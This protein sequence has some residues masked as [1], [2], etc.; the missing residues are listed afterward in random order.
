MA[1][2]INRSRLNSRAN[3][4]PP[5]GLVASLAL[6]GLAGVALL[7][8]THVVIPALSQITDQEPILFWFVWAGF[9]IFVPLIMLAIYLLGQ[10]Q[11]LSDEKA[12]PRLW[13]E[14]LR[15]QPMPRQ[16]WLWTGLGIVAILLLTSLMTA[17]LQL[18]F[19]N[20]NLHPTFMAFQPLSTGRYWILG[21]WLPFWIVNI[22]GEEILW[23]GVVLPRQE[24]SFHQ[25]AW[26]VNGLGWALFHLAFGWQ[27]WLT[28]LPILLIL[29]YIVQRQK[30]SWI[31]VIIHA[32]IN[33]PGFL[34]VAFGLV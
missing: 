31:G 19:G 3:K 2:M 13:L 26:L 12:K 22:M 14:R 5:M 33:G 6:F 27:L 16:D 9:G 25:W 28:L 7:L 1:S 23:R 10:E 4:I 29:P 18:I 20:I 30:N 32:A 34:A 8:I 24:R 17:A 15:F 11:F 21:A